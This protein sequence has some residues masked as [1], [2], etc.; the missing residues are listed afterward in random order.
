MLKI[1]CSL[2]TVLM[3]AACV[4]PPKYSAA[5]IDLPPCGGLPNCVNS[6]A[7]K[8]SQ[9]I[10]PLRATSS[11]WQG[12]KDW[13]GE[14]KDWSVVEDQVN[15]LQFTAV[16]PMMRFRDDIQLLFKPEIELIQVRSSS[17]IGISDMGANRARI[18]RLRQQ[19]PES[20]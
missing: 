7:G 16:T 15:V 9:A 11:Q 17:R 10:D 19:L 18:E 8:G 2:A 13:I 1:L 5:D 14:Q 6:D 4:S 20:R 3:L 12:L